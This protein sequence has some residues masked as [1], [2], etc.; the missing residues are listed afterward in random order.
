MLERQRH[1]AALFVTLTYSEEEVPKD[2]SVDV[3]HVQLFLKRLRRRMEP[4]QVRYFAVGEYGDH[5]LRPHYHALLF[6][7]GDAELVRS[8]WSSGHVY[9]GD[10]TPAAAAYCV[11]YVTKGIRGKE[12]FL[13]RG[14]SYL[15]HPCYCT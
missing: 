8:C 6:G 4:L 14:R 13:R 7:V 15:D 9:V 1:D 11:G 12:W 3:K 5:T 2:G 10:V